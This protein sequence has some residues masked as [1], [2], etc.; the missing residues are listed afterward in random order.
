MLHSLGWTGSLVEPQ[1]PTRLS[2]VDC[3]VDVMA[4]VEANIGVNK[5]NYYLDREINHKVIID[6][7]KATH[8][9]NITFTNNAKSNSWPKGTYKSYQR[10]YIDKRQF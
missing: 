8:S 9:R 2:V 3:R 6:R 1:C 4:Q 10:F 5:A 7:E